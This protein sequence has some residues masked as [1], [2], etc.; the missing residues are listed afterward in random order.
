VGF[1]GEASAPTALLFRNNGLHLELRID[2]S[3][4][5]GKDDPAG[6]ADLV[7]ESAL[8]TIQDCEDSVAAVD[9]ADKVAVYRNW[10][11]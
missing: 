2:R 5:I 6:V 4:V 8:S 7:L 1:T 11:G 10:L 9:A 3:H